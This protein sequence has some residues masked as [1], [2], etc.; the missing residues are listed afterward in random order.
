MLSGILFLH[1]FLRILLVVF[2]ILWQLCSEDEN[3]IIC[4]SK[5]GDLTSRLLYIEALSTFVKI[6]LG[7]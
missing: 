5:K 6:S 3:S 7:K 1:N 4:L 2:L